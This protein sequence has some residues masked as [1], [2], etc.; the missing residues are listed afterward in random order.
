MKLS[1]GSREGQSLKLVTP[2]HGSELAVKRSEHVGARGRR[3]DS[4]RAVVGD[5]VRVDPCESAAKEFTLPAAFV[6][7]REFRI[8]CWGGTTPPL[9]AGDR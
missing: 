9:F 1:S 7:N 2:E 8:R 6:E 3:P 4:K 5:F